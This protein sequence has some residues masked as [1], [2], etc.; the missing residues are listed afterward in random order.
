MIKELFND[1]KNGIVFVMD[2]YPLISGVGFFVIGGLLLFY[3]LKNNNSFKMSEYN[4]L[5]WKALVNT[6][7]VILMCIIFGLILIFK[8]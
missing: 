5:S 3:Q 7:A 2:E 1:F 8:N 6:W 4:V